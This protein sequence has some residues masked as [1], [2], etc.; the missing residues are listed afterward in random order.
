MNKQEITFC[1]FI[2][3]LLTFFL[4]FLEENQLHTCKILWEYPLSKSKIWCG[5]KKFFFALFKILLKFEAEYAVNL[6]CKV[7]AQSWSLLLHKSAFL[8]PLLLSRKSFSFYLLVRKKKLRDKFARYPSSSAMST[9]RMQLIV[10]H[11]IIR[12]VC[13]PVSR[14]QL[15]FRLMKILCC[16]YE[17]IVCAHQLH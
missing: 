1:Y 5:R 12:R 4:L 11:C 3:Y 10:R 17:C 14:T 13:I 2:S 16:V 15:D 9:H 8:I 7:T 6:F